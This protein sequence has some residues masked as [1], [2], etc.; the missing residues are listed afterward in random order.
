MDKADCIFC[1]SSPVTK[2]HL[3]SSWILRLLDR[4]FDTTESR[5][6]IGGVRELWTANHPFQAV[7]RCVCK[8]CNNG[9]MEQIESAAVPTLTRMIRGEEGIELDTATQ[10]AIGTWACLKAMVM[11]YVK[12][13]HPMPQDWLKYLY[14]EHRPPDGWHVFTTR[15][16]GT[17]LQIAESN[18]FSLAP[19]DSDPTT[20][21]AIAE[22]YG[23]LASF[24]IGHVAI[25]ARGMRNMPG[26]RV[27]SSLLKLWPPS[28]LTL[29]WPP[30]VQL[31]DGES[32]EN[33][34][35]MGGDPGPSLFNL[36]PREAK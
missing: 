26:L 21:P 13:K 34:R 7:V 31:R 25:H 35:K 36:P 5:R 32:L 23:V 3:Y 16:F 30:P 6:G 19:I 33:F 12:R 1:G 22:D 14:H 10:E 18:R 29:I 28:P 8:K 15:Y 17:L 27:E 9:W 24:L 2:E 4:E 20:S 11:V